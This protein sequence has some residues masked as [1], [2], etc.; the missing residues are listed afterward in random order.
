LFQTPNDTGDADVGPNNGQNFPVLTSAKNATTTT[1]TGKLNSTPGKTFIVEFFSNPSGTDEGRVFVGQKSVTTDAS[2]NATFT[3]KSATK[4]A[5]GRTITAT[6]T[7]PAGN[8]SEF[9][10]PKTVGLAT[11]SDL[12]LETTKISGPSGL[13]KN[14]TAHFK[15]ASPGPD[16]TFECSLD[17]GGYYPCSSPENINKLSEG[18][19]TFEVRAVDE[20]SNV[21]QSPAAWAWAVKR[22]H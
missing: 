9:S 6:A 19:H 3:F 4:V 5:K 15:F 1:V 2:G 16:A 8:T 14:P 22:N 7:D 10:A 21:D 13:T 17:G 20:Q 11:G 18:R 12:S